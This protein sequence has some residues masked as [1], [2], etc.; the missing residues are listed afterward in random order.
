MISPDKEIDKTKNDF[1]RIS[2]QETNPFNSN[3]TFN[4]YSKNYNNRYDPPPKQSPIHH[5]QPESTGK[6]CCIF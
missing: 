5:K 4:S 6:D 3:N 2:Q 1:A